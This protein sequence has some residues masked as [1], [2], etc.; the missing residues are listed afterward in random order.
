MK[1]GYMYIEIYSNTHDL[2]VLR[3]SY[4]WIAIGKEFYA[5]FFSLSELP[6]IQKNQ[7][8]IGK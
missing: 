6:Q 1:Y 2:K 3:F 8:D 7:T 5:Y 4:P